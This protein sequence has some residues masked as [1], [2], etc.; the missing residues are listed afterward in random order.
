M[1]K[2]IWKDKEYDIS[3][4][5]YLCKTLLFLFCTSLSQWFLNCGLW[6]SDNLLYPSKEFGGHNN[7]L[8]NTKKSLAAFLPFFFLFLPFLLL[9]WGYIVAFTKVTK[10]YQILEFTLTVILLNS[11]LH[12]RNSFNKFHLSIC[13]HMYIV[14]VWYFPTIPTHSYQ[15]PREHLFCLSC[16]RTL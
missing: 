5:C 12:F 1:N 7:F 15:N 4:K 14:F 11:H 13:I 6:Y 10:T 16:S 3:C 8:Y 2:D 9:C